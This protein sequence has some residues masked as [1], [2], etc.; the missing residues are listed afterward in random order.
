MFV[1]ACCYSACG[2][3][4]LLLHS[5]LP[6]TNLVHL[7]LPD[8]ICGIFDRV[9]ALNPASKVFGFIDGPHGIFSG[10]YYL[11]T[12]P[13]VDGFRNTGGFDMLG[14]GRHK[15]ESDEHFAQSL[16]TCDQVLNLDGVVV[17]GG[18]DSNTNAALLGEYFKSKGSKCKV[19]GAPKTIDG[20]LKVMPYIPVSF[21]FDTACRTFSE[22]IGNCCVDSLSAQKYYHFVRLMGRSASNIAIE[23]ALQTLPNFC[24]LGEEVKAKKWGLKDLT[25][26]LVDMIEQR[27]KTQSKNYG[28]VLLPEGLIEFIPEF[29]NL[30]GELNELHEE[31]GDHAQ[32]SDVMAKLHSQENKD[33]FAYLPLFMQKQLLLDRDPHGNVQ[34]AKIETEK[35]L[36]ATVRTELEARLGSAEH[37]EVVFQPQFHAFGYEGESVVSWLQNA[38]RYHYVACLLPD[39][40]IISLLSF[41]F[42]V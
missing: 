25:T 29:E 16:N 8:I 21:G 31:L 11:L 23:C 6:H 24:F 30:I 12:K 9:K 28:V 36:A 14:S 38:Q 10:N 17:I 2:C 1:G 32:P 22:L 39:L 33:L 20:D 41:P 35:L 26:Q 15:I 40:M 34:V 42:V 7:S 3:F 5:F 19:V 4:C 13:I 27:H 18:D 37:A